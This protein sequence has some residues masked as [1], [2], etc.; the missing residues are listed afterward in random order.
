VDESLVG[1]VANAGAVV[2]RGAFVLRPSNPYSES[3]HAFLLA[4]R[5]TGFEGAS[6]PI[7]I[8][9]DGLERLGFIEG[10]VPI[11]PYPAWAQ[12]DRALE[13]IVVLLHSFHQASSLVPVAG[14]WNQE[15]A[16][17]S[18]GSIICH[19][20][21]CLENIVFR[22]G[23]AVAFLD[24]DFAAPGRPVFDL[25]ALARMCVP[26]DDDGNSG[27]LGF[28]PTDRQG[29]L[30]LLADT[31]GLDA[32]G[33]RELIQHLDRSMRGGGA[34][35]KRR[36]ERGDPNFLLMLAEMGGMERYE[37]RTRWWEQTRQSFVDAL[38]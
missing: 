32:D 3:V 5:S 31:Y 26:I 7:E 1:G 18:G 23:T 6:L 2:R 27:R 11:P 22:G 35:V 29:R 28:E 13:S 36:A 16:D 19:N 9:T 12:T 15:L 38:S 10:D 37:R 21:V 4:L 25:A 14:T 24:F 34:F 30:R 33:R 17:P 20:D 8:Q